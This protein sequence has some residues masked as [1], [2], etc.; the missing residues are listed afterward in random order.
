MRSALLL[1]LILVPVLPPLHAL[2]DAGAFSI[3]SLASIRFHPT[4]TSRPIRLAVDDTVATFSILAY[5]PNTGELGGAVQSRV[6]S[7]GNGVLWG[8][9]GVGVVATQ[10]IVDVS[11]GPKALA[12]LRQGMAAADVVKKVWEDDPDPRPENWTKQGR[13]FAVIDAKGNVAAFTGPR[14]SNWAGDKQ[15]RYATAQGNILAGPQ[16][17]QSMIDA[18]EKTTGHM[19]LRLLAALEAGQAA[20]GDTRGMQSA[21]MLIVNKNGGVWLNNDVVLRLQVDDH[22]EPIKE[23]RRLVEI[24]ARRR[25]RTRR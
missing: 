13:Q 14:A 12:Y 20:G 16:V 19:S 23:L 1:G 18:Y 2:R 11:Y 21:A 6:F 10:A 4:R 5:D 22:A 24:A 8:E 15:A 17:V 7:V 25:D 9:A 3:P